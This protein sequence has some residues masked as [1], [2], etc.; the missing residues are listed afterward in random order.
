VIL[1]RIPR[2]NPAGVCR[3]LLSHQGSACCSQRRH[4]RSAP[5]HIP[6]TPKAACSLF[7]SL[8]SHHARNLSQALEYAL[9]KG[10]VLCALEGTGHHNPL[11]LEVFLEDRA[12]SDKKAPL[13]GA[14][15]R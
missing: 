6:R 14:L 13:S 1:R 2:R 5:R 11:A 9:L 12:T 10:A 15:L 3:P 7:A 8:R 4:V